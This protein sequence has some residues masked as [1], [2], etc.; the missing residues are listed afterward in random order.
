MTRYRERQPDREVGLACLWTQAADEAS[1]HL[2]VPDGC[3]D[4]IRSESG[5]IVVAGPDTAPRTVRL[6]AGA[7][8]AAVRFRPGAAPHVLGVPA[9][10]LRDST[11]R[12]D[13][14]WGAAARRITEEA[15]SDDPARVL[16]RV[17]A[18]RLRRAGPPDPAVAVTARALSGGRSVAATADL[19]GVSDRQLRRRCLT[20]F[21]YGPKTLQRILR[22]Q[23]ALALAR[24]GVPLAEVACAAGYADQAHMAREVREL[25]GVPPTGLR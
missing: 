5:R 23:R 24:R 16:Q 20:A 8:F 3:V 9:H 4:I 11:V 13:D 21:G 10:E 6:A 17:V 2:V 14:L 22:F 7:R 15:A 19:L 18:E 1:D 25:A 12:L